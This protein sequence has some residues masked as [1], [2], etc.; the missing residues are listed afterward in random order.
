MILKQRKN[1]RK[2]ERKKKKRKKKLAAI[3]K[4]EKKKRKKGR[5][6]VEL[7]LGLVSAGL[8]TRGGGGGGGGKKKKK[9]GVRLGVVIGAWA[10]HS[11]RAMLDSVAGL[12]IEGELLDVWSPHLFPATPLRADHLI[13]VKML[14]IPATSPC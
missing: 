1:R 3:K 9:G 10:L 12:D 7:V 11:I 5:S 13:Q 6:A 4:E 14:L 2:K 8:S